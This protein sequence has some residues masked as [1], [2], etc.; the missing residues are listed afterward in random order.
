MGPA[1]AEKLGIS[2]AGYVNQVNWVAG[3]ERIIVRRKLEE[4]M[5]VLSLPLPALI[6]VLPDLNTPRIPSLKQVLGAAKKPVANI[7]PADLGESFAP[8]L[9]TTGVQAA[10]M[11]RRRLKFTSEAADIRKIVAAL[12]KEGVIA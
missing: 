4:G 11:E 7:S 3:E 12:L 9:Q 6:T 10:T 2:C 5:E 8:R 1:L